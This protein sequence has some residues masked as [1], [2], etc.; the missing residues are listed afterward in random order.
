MEVNISKISPTYPSYVRLQWD[1]EPD[2]G[3]SGSYVFEVERAGSPGGPWLSLTGPLLDTIFFED[4]YIALADKST[5]STSEAINLLALDKEIYYRVKAT[6]PV[7]TIA[8]SPT[9]DLSGL[10]PP[11]YSEGKVGLGPTVTDAAQRESLPHTGIVIRPPMRKRL[12]LLRRKIMRDQYIGFRFLNGLEAKV[13]KRRHFG[14]HCPIC[15]DPLTDEILIYKCVNCYGTGWVGGFYTP[16]ATY[17]HIQPA[18]VQTDTTPVGNTAQVVTNIR[19]LSYPKV[20][21]GDVLVEVN[22][23]RRWIVNEMRPSEVHRII[24]HQDTLVDE[25][26]RDSIEYLVSVT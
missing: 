22:T 13:L 11:V 26:S 14:T 7:G 15:K 25:L 8:Y 16:I 17:M 3:V 21:K 5:T 6:D 18:A 10:T 4:D 12:R 20:E 23:N 2:S 19:L 1:V 24:V 9:V